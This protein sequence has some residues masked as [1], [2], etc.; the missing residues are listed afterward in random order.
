VPET[1]ALLLN[2]RECPV[3][4]SE[5]PAYDSAAIEEAGRVNQEKLLE[6][7]VAKARAAGLP[8]VRTVAAAGVP[9]T[10]IARVAAERTVDLI[11]IGTQSRNAL[12]GLL[13]GSVAQRVVH[14]VSLPVLLVT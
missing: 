3:D 2:L 13:L 12:A 9:A 1:Q 8:Q 7:A 4:Q 5:L 10:E 6:E 14:L 11:V